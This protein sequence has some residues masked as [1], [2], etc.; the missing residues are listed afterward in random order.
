M[1][2]EQLTKLLAYAP[3]QKRQEIKQALESFKK[4]QA[5]PDSLRVFPKVTVRKMSRRDTLLGYPSVEYEIIIDS[6]AKQQVW[7]TQKI[8]PYHEAGIDRI[9]AFSKAL[10]PFTIVNSLNRSEDYRKLLE[11]GIVLK[12]VNFTTDGNKLITTVTKVRKM[13]IPVAIFQV[14][15]GYVMT[16]LENIMIL[17]IK[18][19]ILNLKNLTPDD[20]PTDDGMPKLPQNNDI[21]QKPFYNE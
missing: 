11:G 6:V 17:D 14:P 1:A 18:N 7:I 21:N 19:N 16:S 9:M 20:N 2:E 3:E 10:N 15:P 13:N 8:K 12:S 4:T 5:E